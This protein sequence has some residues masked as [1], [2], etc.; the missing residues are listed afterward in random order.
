M[1]VFGKSFEFNGVLSDRYDV[2]LCSFNTIDNNRSNGI[3]YKISKGNITE[4]RTSPNFY[5][6]SYGNV[7]EFQMEICKNCGENKFFTTEE[8]I[9]IIRW[10]T[11]PYDYRKFKI[12]DNVGDYY[13]DGIEYF[14]KCKCGYN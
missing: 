13:H 3:S 10:I 14:K 9:E 11:S 4:N 7:L 2:I 6:K 5:G 1:N 12:I 8:Q